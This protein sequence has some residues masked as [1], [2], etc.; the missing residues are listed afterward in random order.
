MQLKVWDI[1]DLPAKFQ[2]RFV[3]AHEIACST[4]HLNEAAPS[5]S[6]KCLS[7]L[8]FLFIVSSFLD[9]ILSPVTTCCSLQ[10]G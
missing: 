9:C 4:F 5:K 3:F 7:N 8:N 10:D 2:C 1:L 6:V